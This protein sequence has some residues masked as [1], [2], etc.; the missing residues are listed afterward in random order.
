M[1][2]WGAALFGDP[3]HGCGFTWSRSP[4]AAIEV[5]RSIPAEMA[6]AAREASGVERGDGWSVAEY[7]LHV[8]D[9]LRQWSERVQAARLG[10]VSDVAGYDPDE[11]AAARSYSAI[12]LPAAMWS[13]GISVEAWV[14]VMVLAV[15]EGVELNH[16]TRGLQR[17]CD[18]ARNN[19][20]DAYHHVWDIRQIV[21]AS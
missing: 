10:G 3:C 8:A 4:S 2:A 19:A 13:L 1:E 11:L 21:S 18:I 7:V 17:A 5:V 6:V 14:D 16:V 20:H 12:P 15:A 9:N